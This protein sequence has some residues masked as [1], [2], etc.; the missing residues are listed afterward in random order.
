[1]KNNTVNGKSVLV[2]D[3]DESIREV[4]Q[5]LL[6]SEGFSVET[7]ENGRQAIE[8]AKE[9]RFDIAL[10]DIVLPDIRGDQVAVEIKKHDDSVRIIF[11]TGY[12]SFQ[13]CIDALDIG[14]SEI[15][16]KPITS[17]ELLTS[18]NQALFASSPEAES[19]VH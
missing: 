13:D 11:I 16:M 18:I 14:V 1:M 10:L 2:V 5:T 4:F 8:K 15:L 6:L 9:A 12:P 7:A 3:D 19:L 17:E